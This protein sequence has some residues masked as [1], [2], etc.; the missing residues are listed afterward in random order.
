MHHLYTLP[1]SASFRAI[2]LF[3][4]SFGPMAYKRRTA[5]ILKNDEQPNFPADIFVDSVS[6]AV[7]QIFRTPCPLGRVPR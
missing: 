2:G 1:P 6:I 5:R 4:Y 7:H 3:G